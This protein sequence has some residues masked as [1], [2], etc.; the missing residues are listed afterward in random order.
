MPE[1]ALRCGTA[2]ATIA[3]TGAELRAWSVGGRAVLWTPDPAFWDATAPILFP[4]VGWTRGAK[5]RVKGQ[6]YPLGLH[7]FARTRAF[8][9]VDATDHTCRL[10]DVADDET[11]ALYPFAYRLTLEFRLGVA[12]L[13]CVAHVAN[14]GAEM[15][16]YAIGLHP[17]FVWPAG[18]PGRIIFAQAETPSVPMITKDGLFSAERKNV[19]LRGR[20]L[21]LTQDLLAN[22]ALCFLDTLSSDFTYEA[23][24]FGRLH[25]AHENFPHLALWSRPPAPYLCIESWTG[26]GDPAGFVGELADKPS[27]RLLPPGAEACHAVTYT[28]APPS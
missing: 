3:S 6:E 21:L 18:E 10:E 24:N 15:M 12:S 25:V 1:T 17:G 28:F 4:V 8:A 20:E 16:P 23:P 26:H 11:S 27:M 2:R 22:E 5:V 13:T 9:V 19:P 14:A 7:G